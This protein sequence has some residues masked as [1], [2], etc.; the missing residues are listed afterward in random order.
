MVAQK[1]MLDQHAKTFAGI[2]VSCPKKYAIAMRNP[3]NF[4]YQMCVAPVATRLTVWPHFDLI[5]PPPPPLSLL[6]DT[7]L[8]G[9]ATRCDSLRR[10]WWR[11]LLSTS[12]LQHYF[13]RRLQFG[14]FTTVSGRGNCLIDHSCISN[15]NFDDSSR[16][17]RSINSV[18]SN[19][20][21]N[22]GVDR[23]NR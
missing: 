5:L 8:G 16:R 17:S 7:P 20:T 19:G 22:S 12:Q 18:T 3:F 6:A 4:V 14:R 1:R 11:G 2:M 10:R 13:A 9:H 23:H 21:G 15:S